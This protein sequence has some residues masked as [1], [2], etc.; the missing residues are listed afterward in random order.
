MPVSYQV[1]L[2]S[3]CAEMIFYR[4]WWDFQSYASTDYLCCSWSATISRGR[5]YHKDPINSSQFYDV[6]MPLMTW[7]ESLKLQ[8]HGAIYR[9]DSF[10]LMLRYCAN[11]KAIRYES[12]SLKRI[13][14]D[15]SR[16]QLQLKATIT[17]CDL[18]PRFF[19]NDPTLL[20]EFESD[21]IWINEFE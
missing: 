1:Y 3:K 8:L 7:T 9:P 19:C 5:V 15:K 11:L 18:S 21:K 17:R 6:R 20:C 2:N 10:V 12:T 14:A 13:V 4:Q 16:V